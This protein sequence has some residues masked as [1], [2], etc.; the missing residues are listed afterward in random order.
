MPNS[1]LSFQLEDA[2][3]QILKETGALQVFDTETQEE[4]GEFDY[5]ED[6]I[7]TNQPALNS[8]LTKEAQKEGLD[9]DSYKIKSFLILCKKEED[10]NELGF[11]E[12]EDA[13]LV[14]SVDLGETE[15]NGS[16]EWKLFLLGVLS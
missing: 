14:A 8:E 3:L 11:I 7:K 16:K 12:N 2:D 6:Q 4:V 15:V 1:N 9:P 5:P 13:I 10:S